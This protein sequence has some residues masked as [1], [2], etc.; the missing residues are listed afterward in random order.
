MTKR[1][2][3]KIKSMLNYY[4]IDMIGSRDEKMKKD[5]LQKFLDT[6]NRHYDSEVIRDIINRISD[7]FKGKHPEQPEEPT[8][9]DLNPEDD[10]DLYAEDLFNDTDS[11]ENKKSNDTTESTNDAIYIKEV[12]SFLGWLYGVLIQSKYNIIITE[13][14]T[15]TNIKLINIK[16]GGKKK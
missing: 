7:K 13:D 15:G 8:T 2:K 4:E 5:E 3:E 10:F 9:D 1:Q 16:K 14:N 11:S 6:F 12:V